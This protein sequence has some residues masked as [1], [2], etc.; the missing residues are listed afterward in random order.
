MKLHAYF[1]LGKSFLYHLTTDIILFLFM[2]S[3]NYWLNWFDFRDTVSYK[4]SDFSLVSFV[5]GCKLLLTLIHVFMYV[6]SYKLY[7]V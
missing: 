4:S 3:Y 5:Q 2:K 7:K 6:I 1:C